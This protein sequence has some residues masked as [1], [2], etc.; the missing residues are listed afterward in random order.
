MPSLEQLIRKN[1]NPFDPTTFRPGNFW[2]ETQNLSHEVTSIHEHVV[3]SVE[4]A[5]D[6]V[7]YDRQTRSL[8]L[9]GESGSGKSYL[10]GR[11]K[12][13]LND[14]ACFAYIGP[15]SDSQHIWRHVLR[16]TVDSLMAVAEG[17]RESQ[18]MRWL[19]GLDFLSG[20]A[21]LSV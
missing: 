19:N 2:K 4:V 6:Q 21:W 15:W 11:I 14:R 7:A 8:M 16:Q 5:L 1:L 18:L 17:Q 10:L 12:R 20:G 9:L 3:D 13:R